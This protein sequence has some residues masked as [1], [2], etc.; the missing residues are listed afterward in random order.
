[1]LF[2]LL[3]DPGELTN[4][5]LDDDFANVR[6][7]LICDLLDHLYASKDPLPIRLSQA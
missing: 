4:L 3:E 5:Y 7:S 6:Q 1:M 2:N